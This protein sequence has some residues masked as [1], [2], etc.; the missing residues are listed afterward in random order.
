SLLEGITINER[1]PSLSE[2]ILHC[3]PLDTAPVKRAGD[4]I[5]ELHSRSRQ[6]SHVSRHGAERFQ[7]RLARPASLRQSSSPSVR[8]NFR[9]SI[10]GWNRSLSPAG[11]I[12]WWERVRLS[13]RQR[14]LKWSRSELTI[15]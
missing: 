8:I 4:E 9:F 3:A 2:R 14:S 15:P 12:S 6:L 10:L 13:I 5:V 7:A 1:R 11:S